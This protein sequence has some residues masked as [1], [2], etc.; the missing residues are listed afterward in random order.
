VNVNNNKY[1]A[2]GV[3]KLERKLVVTFSLNHWTADCDVAW[4][5]E[6]D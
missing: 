5:S 4:L 3:Q 6:E 1:T 2:F